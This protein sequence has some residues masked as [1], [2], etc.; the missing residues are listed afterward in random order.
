M[1]L[2]GG[3][4]LAWVHSLCGGV[5]QASGEQAQDGD[6]GGRGGVG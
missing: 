6:L 2:G 5:E 4:V 3:C 1:V